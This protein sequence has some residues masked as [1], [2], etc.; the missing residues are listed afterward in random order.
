MN[1]I[2]DASKQL[3]ASLGFSFSLGRDRSAA[4]LLGRRET[5]RSLHLHASP[6]PL[7]SPPPLAPSN[8]TAGFRKKKA[9]ILGGAPRTFSNRGGPG[10]VFASFVS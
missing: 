1:R 8:P 6:L 7:D 10:C 5:S 2:H 4:V 9:E 3:T